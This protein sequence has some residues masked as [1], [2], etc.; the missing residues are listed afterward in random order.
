MPGAAAQVS[1]LVDVPD[2]PDAPDAQDDLHHLGLRSTPPRRKV[3][4][5]LR[6]GTRRH[7]SADEV[8]RDLAAAGDDVGLATVYRV[9]AQL[10]QA[11]IVRRTSFDGGKAVFEI[12]EGPHH[13]HLVCV[14]CGGVAEFC[15]DAIEARQHAVAQARGFA[16]VEHRLSLYG[17]CRACTTRG[18]DR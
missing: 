15:D 11:G 8:Y 10:E 17:L 13:D 6:H 7:W 5:L 9:L 4:A 1:V 3:L 2:A 12:D 14:R 16:L 18:A